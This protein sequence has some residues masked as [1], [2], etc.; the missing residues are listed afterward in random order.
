MSLRETSHLGSARLEALPLTHPGVADAAVIPKPDA[1]VGEIPKAFVVRGAGSA[2]TEE[3]LEAFVAG[4]VAGY[5]KVREIEFVDEIPKL[6]SGKILRR[7]LVDRERTRAGD[8]PGV[9]P[10]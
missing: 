3:E 5:K 7:I 10:A 9:S 1:E 6:P 8:P 2:V 4:R